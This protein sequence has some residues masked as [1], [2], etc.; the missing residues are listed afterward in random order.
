MA[1]MQLSEEKQQELIK[2]FDKVEQE[3]IGIGKR[4]ELLNTLHYLSDIYLI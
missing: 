3:K 4:Q 1:D 2:E